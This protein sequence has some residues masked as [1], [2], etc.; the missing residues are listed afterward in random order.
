VGDGA[1]AR[2]LD[3][4]WS[5]RGGATGSVIR[6]AIDARRFRV[7]IQSVWPVLTSR[8]WETQ[9]LSARRCCASL[10]G[11]AVRGDHQA[12]GSQRS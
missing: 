5:D 1:P 8:T 7:L 6:G 10:Y 11:P 3:A 2:V 9:Q 12:R 4:S